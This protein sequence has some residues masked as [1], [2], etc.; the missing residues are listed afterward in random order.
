M[1]GPTGLRGN[2][3]GPV[4]SISDQGIGDHRDRRDHGIHSDSKSEREEVVL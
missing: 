2:G 3:D 4:E 1:A